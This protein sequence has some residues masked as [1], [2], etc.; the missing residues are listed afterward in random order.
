MVR[1]LLAAAVCCTPLFAFAQPSVV[2]QVDAEVRANAVTRTLPVT[3]SDAVSWSQ[4]AQASVSYNSGNAYLDHAVQILSADGTL[5]IKRSAQN[6]YNHE[7][8]A[9]NVSNTTSDLVRVK[10]FVRGAPGTPYSFFISTNSFATPST[11]AGTSTASTTESATGASSFSFN[12][13]RN[14][15]YAQGVSTSETIT[16]MGETYSAVDLS[17]SSASNTAYNFSSVNTVSP[18][19]ANSRVSGTTTIKLKNLAVDD[20]IL[21]LARVQDTNN[22]DRPSVVVVP[23]INLDEIQYTINGVTYTQ[24][25]PFAA[26]VGQKVLMPDLNG[27]APGAYTVEFTGTQGALTTL[28]A[29]TTLDTSAFSQTLNATL[30]PVSGSAGPGQQGGGVNSFAVTIS[31]FRRAWGLP[32][33]RVDRKITSYSGALSSNFFVGPTFTSNLQGIISGAT[34][35]APA[36]FNAA[37]TGGNSGGLLTMT[38]GTLYTVYAKSGNAIEF[39]LSGTRNGTPWIWNPGS[40]SYG[41][42][43]ANIN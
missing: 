18:F 43:S 41:S 12:A 11:S 8:L 1:E 9:P 39:R 28:I 36:T 23:D 19:Y 15:R 27:I 14:S 17:C 35:G 6:V 24:A 32:G 25:G 4:R 42:V 20:I 29:A 13:G 26:N 34:F 30:Q 22:P 10:A 5:S 2:F 3:T 21:N 33:T 31:G 40:T 38:Y 7:L 37:G 16:H